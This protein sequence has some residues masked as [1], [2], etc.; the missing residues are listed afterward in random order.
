MDATSLSLSGFGLGVI[1]VFM[2]LAIGR[3]LIARRIAQSSHTSGR[4][5]ATWEILN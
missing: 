5:T 1:G 4:T 2:Y 3:H